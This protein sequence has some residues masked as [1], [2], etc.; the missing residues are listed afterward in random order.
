MGFPE[1]RESRTPGGKRCRGARRGFTKTAT[2]NHDLFCLATTRSCAPSAQSCILLATML[3]P[4]QII[5]IAVFTLAC[6]VAFYALIGYPLLLDWLAKRA[7]NPVHKDDK[8]RSVSF[9][10]AV[11]NGEKFLER[12]LRT[13]LR[14]RSA[15]SKVG[16]RPAP[17][18]SRETTASVRSPACSA[19]RRRW[20]LG[21]TPSA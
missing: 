7:D 6:V 13:I 9:V 11:Y 18:P 14:W 3:S 1:K 4:A 12:K 15:S 16:R 21:N 5:S 2:F 20:N 10:I 8:L 17:G 19:A